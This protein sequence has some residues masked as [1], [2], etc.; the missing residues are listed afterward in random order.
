M[1]TGLHL[2]IPQVAVVNCSLLSEFELKGR[3]HDRLWTATFAVRRAARSCHRS[4]ARAGCLP[5]L[6]GPCNGEILPPMCGSAR[7][8][9]PHMGERVARC[10]VYCL[11]ALLFVGQLARPDDRITRIEA[12]TIGSLCAS[13]MKAI[14]PS[15]LSALRS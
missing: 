2:H 1:T 12:A 10:G 3:L 9:R 7:F 15:E 14:T 8:A 6:L 5:E 11:S 4:S 13:P